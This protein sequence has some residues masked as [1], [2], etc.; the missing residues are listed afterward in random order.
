MQYYCWFRG[1]YYA[2]VLAGCWGFAMQLSCWLL[3]C[4]NIILLVGYILAMQLFLLVAGMLLCSCSG[5]LLG[6]CYVV[7]QAS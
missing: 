4:C 2:V 6:F 1:C 7:V 5:W 3:G